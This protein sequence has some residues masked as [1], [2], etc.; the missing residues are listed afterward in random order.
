[1]G[2]KASKNLNNHHNRGERDFSNT[3]VC[4]D[5]TNKSV[6]LRKEHSK[7]KQNGRNKNK[8]LR[9]RS[10]KASQGNA[11]DEKEDNVESEELLGDEGTNKTNFPKSQHLQVA[12]SG[13]WV[14]CVHT[15]PFKPKVIAYP[16]WKTVS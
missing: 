14:N 13:D 2:T 5:A 9:A 6:N 4:D 12:S 15:I 16:T 3:V 10:N 11:V 8:Y 7:N 1:M